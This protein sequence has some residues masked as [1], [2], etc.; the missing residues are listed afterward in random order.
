MH[1]SHKTSIDSNTNTKNIQI[2]TIAVENDNLCGKICD[3]HFAEICGNMRMCGNYII[4]RVKQTYSL[5]TGVDPSLMFRRMRSL[6]A[7]V[8][9]R[10]KRPRHGEIR[11]VLYS[12][13]WRTNVAAVA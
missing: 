10:R 13:R 11:P 12:A 7:V 8:N 6:R 9:V 4:I 2:T 3:A 1:N 5:L